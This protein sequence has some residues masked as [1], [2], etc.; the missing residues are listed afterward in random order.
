[1]SETRWERWGR[2][3]YEDLP[4]LVARREMLRATQYERIL[5]DLIAEI[6][7]EVIELPD[8]TTESCVHPCVYRAEARLREV[9]GE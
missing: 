9:G 3:R 1:M 6:K 8:G 4:V 7:E 2:Y 5:L